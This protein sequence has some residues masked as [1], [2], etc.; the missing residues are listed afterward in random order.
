[1]TFGR[2]GFGYGLGLGGL[3]LFALGPWLDVG[4]R[5]LPYFLQEPRWLSRAALLGAEIGLSGLIAG[6]LAFDVTARVRSRGVRVLLV[7]LI[8]VV[9]MMAIAIV[10]SLLGRTFEVPILVFYILA[11]P[12]PCL[13]AAPLWAL[14]YLWLSHLP[15][16]DATG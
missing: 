2:N 11:L 8:V 4:L 15:H 6:W 1:M 14:I 5:P 16:A 13:V 9:L 7:T 3:L 12:L 10:L